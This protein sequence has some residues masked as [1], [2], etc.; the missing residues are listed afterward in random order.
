MRPSERPSS[1]PCIVTD[2]A[3][4]ERGAR[5]WDRSAGLQ[6]TTIARMSRRWRGAREIRSDQRLCG[7]R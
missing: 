1:A 6:G 2:H 7:D 3:A 5:R 4:P